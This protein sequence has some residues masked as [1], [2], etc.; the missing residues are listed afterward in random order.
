MLKDGSGN[1]P[2]RPPTTPT[3]PNHVLD[4]TGGNLPPHVPKGMEGMGI[5]SIEE[6]RTISTS[7]SPKLAAL[8]AS[9][10]PEVMAAATPSLNEQVPDTSGG[11]WTESTPPSLMIPYPEGTKLRLRPLN[12]KALKKAH[13]SQ[14][15]RSFKLLIEAIQQCVSMDVRHLTVPDFYYIMYWLR[16]NSYPSSPF[17]LDWTSR[18]GNQ[19]K[20]H[21]T[22]SKFKITEFGITREELADFQR[23]G[24]DVPRIRDYEYISSSEEENPA[25]EWSVRHAQFLVV[26]GLDPSDPDFM[27]KK[28]E[29]LE[30]SEANVIARIMEF[31]EKV[32]HG[33][34]EQL[35]VI[36][37]DFE[38]TKALTHLE[39]EIATLTNIVNVAIESNDVDQM[40]S[41][42]AIA[43]RVDELTA[44]KGEI[45]QAIE[46]GR[47]YTPRME[48]VELANADPTLLFP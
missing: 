34:I 1:P 42:S 30:S 17:V 5:E 47:T 21:V 39:G 19:N 3:T 15:S 43:A 13:A 35:E 11:D 45:E 33:V 20:Q 2:N 28:I 40:S 29:L 22:M 38:P 8:Q 46:E 27:A 4:L 24:L 6:S 23:Q 37:T 44:E 31:S 41:I 16:M 25:D 12:V 32:E 10:S 14:D 26:E 9:A 36:D 7:T 48:V 18:Y